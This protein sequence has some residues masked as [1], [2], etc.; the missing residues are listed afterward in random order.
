MISMHENTLYA[1][2]IHKKRFIKPFLILW[3]HFENRTKNLLSILQLLRTCHIYN[4][5]NIF[6]FCHISTSR[7]TISDIKYIYPIDPIDLIYPRYP[8]TS[9]TI[10][11]V[12]Y[13][14]AGVELA[15]LLGSSLSAQAL[16]N[17]CKKYSSFDRRKKLGTKHTIVVNLCEVFL[18][19]EMS[20]CLSEF[21]LSTKSTYIFLA[22]LTILSN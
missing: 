17:T 22:F 14:Q 13:L 1:I 12:E 7:S 19:M 15:R 5:N 21:D 16:T 8:K 2:A 6:N 20:S 10:Q 9:D 18:F 11:Y 4:I 3:S